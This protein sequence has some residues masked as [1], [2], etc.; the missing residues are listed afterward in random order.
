[1]KGLNKSVELYAAQPGGLPAFLATPRGKLLPEYLASVSKQLA[2][3]NRCMLDELGSISRNI[4]HI[5]AIVATQQNYT[6]ASGIVEDVAVAELVE[7]ALCMGESSFAKHGID[8]RRDFA[9]GVRAS[10]DR[11]KLLQI[12]VNLVTNARHAVTGVDKPQVS[13][14]IAAT[15][16]G[17]TIS[18][19]DTGVGIPSENL[20]R[21]FAHGF[22]TKPDGHG[23]G[24]HS[25][26][27]TAHELGGSLEVSSEG[28]GCGATF[29]LTLPA[30]SKARVIN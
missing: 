18:I 26:A 14:T 23:F 27:N 12:L 11:H 30:T 17:I 22:T 29:T 6:R 7:E 5:K 20:A 25:S 19:A 21:I 13:A 15:E 2:D 28:S 24:L 9:P 3:E 1:V 16:A 10:T 8:V 4:E